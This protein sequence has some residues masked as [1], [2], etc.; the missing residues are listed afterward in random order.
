MFK[1]P[2]NYFFLYF[3]ENFFNFASHF[4]DFFIHSIFLK[5]PSMFHFPYNFSEFFLQFTQFFLRILHLLPTQFRNNFFF[6][7]FHYFPFLTVSRCFF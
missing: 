6:F 7:K 3:P 4:L 2:R 1:F 5:F